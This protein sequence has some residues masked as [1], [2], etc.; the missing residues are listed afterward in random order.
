MF[1]VTNIDDV[2][3]HNCNRY[4]EWKRVYINIYI[5]QK[6]VVQIII[7]VYTASPFTVKK[8][9]SRH[10]Y[11]YDNDN[12]TDSKVNIILFVF[13]KTIFFLYIYINRQSRKFPTWFS[14]AIK[15]IRRLRPSYGQK[16]RFAVIRTPFMVYIFTVFYTSGVNEEKNIDR[17]GFYF[18]RHCVNR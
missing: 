13:L 4:I 9:L 11:K 2:R 10:A 8:F 16:L 1:K 7:I 6:R 18:Y 17:G 5:K 15:K 14:I 3:V 12:K